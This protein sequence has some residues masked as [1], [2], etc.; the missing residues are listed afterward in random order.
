MGKMIWAI[1]LFALSPVKRLNV[2]T[3]NA[4]LL[5]IRMQWQCVLLVCIEQI[6]DQVLKTYANVLQGIFETLFII[7]E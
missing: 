7:N 2:E 6:N 4:N 3:L 5:I 1:A